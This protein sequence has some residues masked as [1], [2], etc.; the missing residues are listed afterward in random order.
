MSV[1]VAGQRSM[2]EMRS[3]EVFQ[4]GYASVCVLCA[5]LWGSE[6]RTERDV[7]SKWGGSD[8]STG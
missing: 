1:V 8:F 5:V 3:G 4:T 2:A 7:G 6:H